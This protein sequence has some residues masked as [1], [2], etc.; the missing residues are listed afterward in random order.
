MDW[1]GDR[2]RLSLLLLTFFSVLIGLLKLSMQYV[3]LFLYARASGYN[4]TLTV[5][6]RVMLVLVERSFR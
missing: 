3:K 1:Y 6:L 4:R 5:K 2:V